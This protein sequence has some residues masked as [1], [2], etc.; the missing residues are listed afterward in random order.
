MNATMTLEDADVT[1]AAWRVPS[2]TRL[3]LAADVLTAAGTGLSQPFLLVLLTTVH[4]YGVGTA[5][6]ISSIAAAV[7]LVGNPLAGSLID[8]WGGR[9]VML[10]GLGT[11]GAGLA[12]LGLFSAPPAGPAGVALTGFGWSLALPAL[13]TTLASTVP[14]ARHGR[15]FTLQYALFNAGMGT[16]ALI[17]GVVL[18]GSPQRLAALWLVAAATCAI[19]AAVVWTARVG[20]PAGAAEPAAG[21][22]RRVLADRRLWRVLGVAV[23]LATAGYGVFNVGPAMLALAAHDSVAASWA[24]VANGAAIVLGLPAALRFGE[25][26]SPYRSLRVAAG[27]W[28][29]AW[30]LCWL[31]A[32]ALLGG[33]GAV[34]PVLAAAAALVGAGELALAAALPALVNALAPDELRGRYNALL[35]L[36]TTVG[37]WAG[38]VLAGAT[39][40]AGS[41]SLLFAAATV[42]PLAAAALLGRAAPAA[43]DHDA[44]GDHGANDANDAN[45]VNDVNDDHD[46]DDGAR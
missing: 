35:T 19:S 33:P 9:R 17:G 23:G 14:P 13:A 46:A 10:A 16:G 22:Y 7:S 15:I 21:G 39:V 11:A 42:I 43:N 29:A 12:L 24:G 1:A 32:A 5:A 26:W 27:L 30:A 2:R 44:N 37:Q 8:R 34:R 28:A 3:L 4:G 36:A 41:P 18:A 20:G 25:R 38:P 40:R 6:V 45:D 31:H